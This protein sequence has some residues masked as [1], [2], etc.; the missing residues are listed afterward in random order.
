MQR[1]PPVAN[2]AAQCA[3]TMP[4][5]RLKLQ[6]QPKHLLKLKKQPNKKNYCRNDGVPDFQIRHTAVSPRQ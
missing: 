5:V 6:K 2:V 4:K 1:L 3:A